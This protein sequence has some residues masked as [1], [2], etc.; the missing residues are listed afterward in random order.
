MQPMMYA[1]SN[2]ELVEKLSASQRI[3]R[4]KKTER[5]TDRVF[6][7][8]P[9]IEATGDCSTVVLG[10]LEITTSLEE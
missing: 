7:R 2:L 10:P 6:D 1:V 5:T 4:W 9:V 3:V 8:N